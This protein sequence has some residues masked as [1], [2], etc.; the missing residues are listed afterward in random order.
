MGAS[1]ASP[2]PHRP[3]TSVC[4]HLFSPTDAPL[5]PSNGKRQSVLAQGWHW[6]K[7]AISPTERK[8][9]H[10]NHHTSRSYDGP[11]W[12][13]Q[14]ELPYTQLP[15]TV[16]NNQNYRN[17]EP[18]T[19]VIPN[20]YSIRDELQRESLRFSKQDFVNN[21]LVS[22]LKDKAKTPVSPKHTR[23]FTHVLSKSDSMCSSQSS[24]GIVQRVELKSQSCY[25]L[26]QLS[27]NEPSISAKTHH[28]PLET[29]FRR[30]TNPAV[31][32]SNNDTNRSSARRT[33]VQA[34]TSE[35]LRALGT[36]VLERCPVNNF[37]PAH[38]VMWLRT[39]DRALL[40]QGWQDVAFINPANL[41]FVYLLVRD[42]L[43]GDDVV[44]T[45]EEL[46]QWLLTCLYIGYSY[47]GNEISYPLKPFIIESDRE[48]F[49]ERTVEIIK[50]KSAD[51]L[52]LNASS[53]FF[54]EIFTELK[55]YADTL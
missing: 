32:Q 18:E 8:H 23:H 49:W 31:H 4:N 12:R 42:V 21:N 7:K 37:E 25:R 28:K 34:S 24:Q 16:D 50:A 10:E 39:V 2:L 38:V 35:L 11:T 40:L 20:Y 9:E 27:S 45:L 41:V 54:T 29:E 51:M 13:A 52:R 19:T 46:H 6:G 36:F 55:R 1:L 43:P 30:T 53:A 44:K 17:Y 14:R 3:P 5:F 33:V 48:R 47:M 26:S 22:P 15:I